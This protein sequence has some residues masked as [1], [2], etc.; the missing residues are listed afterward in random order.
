MKD[1]EVKYHLSIEHKNSRY[2]A[3]FIFFSFWATFGGKMGVA[4]MRSHVGLQT[5]IQT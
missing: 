5:N 2:G 4:T 1:E 3:Y